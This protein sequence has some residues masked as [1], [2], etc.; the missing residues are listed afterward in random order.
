MNASSIQEQ[1]QVKTLHLLSYAYF[2]FICYLTIGLPL[3]VLPS[4]AH[5]DLG[6]S[7]VIAGLVISIQYVATLVSRPAVGRFA[8]RRGARPAV[9]SGLAVGALSGAMLLTAGFFAVHSHMLALLVLFVSRLILGVGESL[10]STGSTLWSIS[11]NG[12]QHTAKIISYNGVSTYGGMALG[13]PLGV[14]L[15]TH[16]GLAGIGFVVLTIGLLS[17][18]IALRKPASAIHHGEHLPIRD[19]FRRVVMHGTVLALGGVGFSELATFVTLYYVSR[20]WDGAALCLTAFGL[21]FILTRLLFINTIALFGTFQVAMAS[22]SV[23][24]AG[25][26]LIWSAH[27]PSVALAGSALTGFGFSLVF[28]S[29]GLE[30]VKRVPVQNRGAALGIYTGFADISFFLTGPSSGAIIGWFGYGAIFVF[31]MAAVLLALGL[32][33]TLWNQMRQEA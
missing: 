23:E 29:I 31:A 25:L 4:F 26:F 33:F 6:Y 28:P 16:W 22:L 30:V 19:I 7:A 8:D 17:L 27:S 20:H 21:A 14:W 3:A 9:V 11:A 18:V 5:F 12:S 10:T 32:A 1:K 13:A 15:N 2:T 24:L